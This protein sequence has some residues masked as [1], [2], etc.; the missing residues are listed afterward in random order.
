MKFIS[1]TIAASVLVFAGSASAMVSPDLAREVRSAAGA[2]SNVRVC[3][4]GDTVTLS[5]YA[6]DLYAVGLAESAARSAGAV[7][8]INR[9]GRTN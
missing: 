3:I 6:E 2:N 1:Q 4:E 7:K 5:G 9:I 8:V